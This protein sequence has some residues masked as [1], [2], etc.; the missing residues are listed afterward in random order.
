MGEVKAKVVSVDQFRLDSSNIR[1]HSD[2]NLDAIGASIERFGL[3]RSGVVDADGV[4]RA[5]NGTFEAAVRQGLREVVL[6]EPEPGQMVMVRRPEWSEVESKAY[7]LAD[8][9]TSDLSTFDYQ[10][11]SLVLPEMRDAGLHPEDLGWES[12]EIEPLE[13]A[14]WSPPERVEG[15]L[16]V[17]TTAVTPPVRLSLEQR[18]IFERALERLR[19]EN[20]ELSEG[21]GL[22]LLALSYLGE[23]P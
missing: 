3:A 21:E 15:A 1:K 16:E 5:G 7:S 23:Q 4:V 18:K 12:W 20:G 6:V 14:K 22:K 19:S 17:D 2:R 9:K 13:A 10:A 11:L 8:N